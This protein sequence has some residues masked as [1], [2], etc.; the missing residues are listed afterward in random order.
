MVSRQSAQ[1]DQNW[2][3]LPTHRLGVA[4]VLYTFIQKQRVMLHDVD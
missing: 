3:G 1:V 4:F 2:L